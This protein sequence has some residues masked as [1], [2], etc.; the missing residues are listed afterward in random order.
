[1]WWVAGGGAVGGGTGRRP[2][3]GQSLR[4]MI[5]HRPLSSPPLLAPDSSGG[6]QPPRRAHLVQSD[7]V[8]EDRAANFKQVDALLAGVA[9]RPGDLV[10]LPEMFDTGFS[11]NLSRTADTDGATLEYLCGLARRL[12]CVVQGA[13]TVIGPDGRGRNAAPVIGPDGAV[14]VE[15]HKVHPF[16]FGKESEHFSGGERVV[17]Y[18]LPAAGV[19][20]TGVRVCPAICYDLRFPEV[21]RLGLM[22]GAEVFAVSANWPSVRQMHRHTLARARAIENQA[23]VLCLNRAGRDPTLVYEGGTAAYDAKGELL[24]ELGSGAAVLSV[25]M[26]QTAIRGWRATFPAWRDG[27]LSP[28]GPLRG[29]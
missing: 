24:G 22:Q 8:W 25:E 3:A 16:S 5:H 15:Y 20:G 11:F 27:R 9:V 2:G 29:M 17:C 6:G 14:L 18:D 23:V 19:D 12:G 10:L 7:T 26:D 4:T 1:M 13:R 21:F 28:V